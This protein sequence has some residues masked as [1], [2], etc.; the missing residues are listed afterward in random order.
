MHGNARRKQK[1]RPKAAGEKSLSGLFGAVLG[2]GGVNIFL[3]GGKVFFLVDAAQQGLAHNVAVPV[4]DV[5]GGESMMF[6]ANLPASLP[7]AK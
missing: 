6:S 1:S 4:K 7:E 3:Q 2:K 5:G